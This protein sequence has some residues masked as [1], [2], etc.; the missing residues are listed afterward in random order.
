M[1]PLSSLLP[2]PSS[3]PSSLFHSGQAILLSPLSRRGQRISHQHR[4][5]AA[6]EHARTRWYN[7]YI[8]TCTY[9][10]HLCPFMQSTCTCTC[11]FHI[12]LC[13]LSSAGLG[14]LYPFSTVDC[15]GSQCLFSD[16]DSI[17]QIKVKKEVCVL[18]THIPPPPSFH[19]SIAPT[20]TCTCTCMCVIHDTYMYMCT[21]LHVY[22][23]MHM[24]LFNLFSIFLFE[25]YVQM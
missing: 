25:V 20:C 14:V 24:R 23:N 19:H 3:L 18:C 13:F 8:H 5:T 1:N 10:L 21:C 22:N 6:G 16:G 4:D 2:S 17:G 15:L 9:T 12:V 7:L 11:A